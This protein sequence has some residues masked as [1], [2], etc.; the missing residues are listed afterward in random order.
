MRDHFASALAALAAATRDAAAGPEQA[1]LLPPTTAAQGGESPAARRVTFMDAALALAPGL[2]LGDVA[3]LAAAAAPGLTDRCPAV[4]KRAYKLLATVCAGRP[5]FLAEDRGADGAGLSNVLATLL[6]A[7]PRALPA[8]KRHR[9]AVVQ[10][11]VLALRAQ[12]GGGG[13]EGATPSAADAGA[14]LIA[15]AV[16]A[17]KEANRKTRSAAYDLL[18]DL[19]SPSSDP[20]GSPPGTGLRDLFAV[21]LGGLAGGSPHMVSAST[22]AAARLV[23]AY[24]PGPLGSDAG[25]LLP[26]ILPLLRTPAREVIKSVLGF[27]KVCVGRLPTADLLAATPDLLD[28]LLRWSDDPKNKF[29]LKVRVIVERLAR[30]IGFEAV[31]ASMPASDAKLLAHIRKQG[32][33]KARKKAAGAEAEEE[34]SDGEGEGGEGEEGGRSA[35][36][37]KAGG[38]AG[39]AWAPTAL[40]SARTGRTGFTKAGKGGAATTVRGGRAETSAAALPGDRAGAADPVDLLGGGAARA[41]AGG[42]GG[43]AGGAPG[44][45]APGAGSHRRGASDDDSDGDFQEGR[46]GRLV[47][48]ERPKAGAKRGRAAVNESDDDDD[49]D[50]SGGGG[51]GGGSAFGGGRARSVGGAKSVGGRSAR[52][53]GGRSAATAGAPAPTGRTHT[54]ARFRAVKGGASGDVRR[55]GAKTEPYAYW[56]MDRSMLNRRPAKQVSAAKGLQGVVQAGSKGRG[57]GRA[58]KRMKG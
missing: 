30:R 24:V 26:A 11:A 2:P 37:A 50:G 44:R 48:S 31:A 47:I 29:R 21:V 35:R 8:A 42:R 54:G 52:S 53:A 34:W 13:S 49:D 20:P 27:I 51:R 36:T 14:T 43:G 56:P 46:D 58:A 39:S 38:G 19:G 5:D 18:V 15:E 10:E 4:Q 33:R 6:A 3:A 32:A 17:T 9:L 45:R 57:G 16:L 7:G 28:G 23:H 1:A 55:S 22:M 40:F 25:R 41:L 12:G